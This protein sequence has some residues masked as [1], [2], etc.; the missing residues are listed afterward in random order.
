M[1]FDLID[2]GGSRSLPPDDELRRQFGAGIDAALVI[3]GDATGRAHALA[4]LAVNPKDVILIELGTECLGFYVGEG[5]DTA[6]NVAGFARFRLGALP[7][8]RLVELVR[9][10]GT[11]ALALQTA[12]SM[13]EAG[14]VDVVTCS[15]EPGRIVDNLLRPYLNAALRSVDDGLATPADLDQALRLGLGFPKGP[16]ELLEGSGVSAH[17]EVSNAL[18]EA[19]GTPEFLPARRARVEA[20]RER[21]GVDRGT[22]DAD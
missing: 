12:R 15:D 7:P 17:F 11:S 5:N 2:L 20:M 6:N 8:S 22:H 9:K 18:Y 16:I 1:S 4:K 14:G 3:G 21:A 19:R 10:P 13:F